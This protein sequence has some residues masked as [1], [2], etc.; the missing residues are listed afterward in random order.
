[1]NNKSIGIFDSGVG[2]M[3][4]FSEI[5]KALPN[6]NI[7][8]LGDTKNFPYGTKSK[9][10]IV[11]ISKK[12]VEFL[13]TK[14]VKI[15]VIA[16]GTATSQALEELKECYNIPII[17][18]IEPTVLDMKNSEVNITNIGVIATDGTIRSNQ[19]ERQIKQQMPNVNVYN[20]ACPLL[21][22]MAEEGWVNNA[23]AKAAIDE[24]LAEFSK[25]KLDKLILGCTH[26][27]LFEKV[28]RQKLGE[29]VSII[30][31]G[32][33]IAQYL[34]KY[35]ERNSLENSKENIANNSIYLT[36]IECNFI[37]V[38]KKIS[39]NLKIDESIQKVNIEN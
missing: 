20:K 39:E 38:A 7:V 36:D 34:K 2:G 21:A 22:P 25:L 37:K 13:I 35:L 9:E 1:M 16:C 12:C 3:T 31:T 27:P 32:T 33:K 24:Y 11:K 17:G 30:N 19:W 28:I 6:E 5:S 26:Y 4:V 8:Y 15:I 23:V 18:I 29:N 14:N 10:N